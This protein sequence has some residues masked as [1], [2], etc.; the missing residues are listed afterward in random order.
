VGGPKP[1]GGQRDRVPSLGRQAAIEDGE[2]ACLARIALQRGVQ[3]AK[4]RS[5]LGDAVVSTVVSG[6]AAAAVVHDETKGSDVSGVRCEGSSARGGPQLYYGVW[7][8]ST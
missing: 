4:A 3:T 2:S 5:E 1:E 6:M 7:R 8:R